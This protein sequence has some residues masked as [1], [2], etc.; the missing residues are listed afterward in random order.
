MNHLWFLIFFWAHSIL[1]FSLSHFIIVG[2]IPGKLMCENE[3]DW[4]CMK[5]KLQQW[6]MGWRPT[7]DIFS[8][9]FSLDLLDAMILICF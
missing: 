4:I 7:W 2:A 3:K 5:K 9:A 1:P 8:N 6:I